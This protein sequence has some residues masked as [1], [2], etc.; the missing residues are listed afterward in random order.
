M[1]ADHPTFTVG[2]IFFGLKVLPDEVN[3][4]I[5]RKICQINWKK[6]VGLDFVQEEDPYGSIEKYDKI[7]DKILME[8]PHLDY[9]KCYHAGETRNHT[10][11]NIEIAVRAGSV[12][13]GHGI[14]ILQRIDFLPHCSNICFEKNPISNLVTAA[15]K[16]LDLRL[17]SAPVLLGLGYPVTINPDD[18]GKFGYEDTTVDYFCTAVSYNWTL[19]HLKLLAVHSINHAICTEGVRIKLLKSFNRRWDEWINGF[20]AAE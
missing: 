8:F 11:N 19:K 14:N 6:T 20:L 5:L 16:K 2:F 9:K 13:L 1:K 10:N 4:A 12:R 7:A 18:P 17:S 15:S 3:E